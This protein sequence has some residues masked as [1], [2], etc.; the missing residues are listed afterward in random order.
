MTEG[1]EF[2]GRALLDHILRT[3][4][5]TS[6]SPYQFFHMMWAIRS[7]ICAAADHLVYPQPLWLQTFLLATMRRVRLMHEDCGGTPAW[8]P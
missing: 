6:A 3:G 8:P 7:V 2:L 1:G 4:I 5:V